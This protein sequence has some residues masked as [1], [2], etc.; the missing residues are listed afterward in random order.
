MGIINVKISDE[1]ETAFRLKLLLHRGSKKGAMGKAVDEALQLWSK[2]VDSKP[3]YAALE[4]AVKESGLSS[5]PEAVGQI[6]RDWFNKRE[7]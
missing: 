3:V 6:I 4:E 7:G 2:I 5:V 1:T